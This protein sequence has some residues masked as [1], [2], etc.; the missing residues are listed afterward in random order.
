[1]SNGFS[2]ARAHLELVPHL[3]RTFVDT[4]APSPDTWDDRRSSI[5]RTLADLSWLTQIRLKYCPPV[6][7]IDLSAGGAQ[8][9]IAARLELGSTVVMQIGAESETFTVPSLVLR[10]QVS[11][12]VPEGTTYRTALAFKRRL[13]R[14]EFLE[15]KKSDRDRYLVDE[16]SK[17]NAALRRLE[18]SMPLYEGTTVPAV[19][20]VGRG[21]LAAALAI[22]ESPSEPRPSGTFSR[23]MSR[24]FRLITSGLSNGTA[25]HAILEQ[26]VEGLRRAVPAQVIRVVKGDS[27][28]GIPAEANCFD[29]PSPPG[30]CATRLVVECPLGCELDSEHL[31]FLKAAAHLVTLIAE[32][33]QVKGARDRAA[34][35]ETNGELPLGWKRLVVRYMDG[36]LLKGFTTD[37]AGA[38]GYVHVWMA[39]NGPEGS[40]VTVP[41]GH[42]KAIFFVHDFIGD[43][44]YRPGVDSSTERGRR[45]EVTFIDGEMLAG[46]TL[47]YSPEGR[48]F[49]VTPLDARDN[50]VRIFIAPGAVRHVKFP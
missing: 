1:M 13:E 34:S 3:S 22:M 5:R 19:T 18:E 49:F 50:N 45:I 42:L 38:R 48:G 33:D 30:G 29:V 15:P 14:P 31:S 8:I 23:E 46:T 39:P 2:A 40:R 4:P 21:A 41:L 32:I 28:V 11:R 26:M 24:L 35:P 7:L 43:P 9:E 10:S 25:P 36:R 17:L 47:T 20:G 12:I 44:A 16:H 27:L 6:A 37:F